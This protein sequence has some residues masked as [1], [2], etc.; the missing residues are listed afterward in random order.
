MIKLSDIP[1]ISRE[2]KSI[3][4]KYFDFNAVPGKTIPL[5]EKFLEKYPYYPEAYNFM[6]VL[7]IADGQPS[8]AMKYIKAVERIDEW[9]LHGVFDKAEILIF[10][11]KYDEGISTF[12]NGIEAYV[13][14]LRHGIEDF[15]DLSDN[16]DKERIKKKVFNTLVDYFKNDDDNLE[17]FEKLK[18]E[19]SVTKLNFIK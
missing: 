2:F 7:L 9:R 14:E 16:E 11:D 13:E 10:K 8:K 18:K 19:L 17:T 5:V 4:K 1:H 12:I 3:Y 15:L 6:A